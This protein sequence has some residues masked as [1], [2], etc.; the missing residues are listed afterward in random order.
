MTL[1]IRDILV[2]KWRSGEMGFANS[3][4]IV[5][6]VVSFPQVGAI[7]NAVNTELL[8]CTK[9]QGEWGGGERKGGSGTTNT[10]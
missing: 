6:L 7:F 1:D 10:E 3:S 8:L 5:T 9:L 4:L 2:E